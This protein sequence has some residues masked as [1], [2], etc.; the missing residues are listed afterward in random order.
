MGVDAG[1]STSTCDASCSRSLV[2]F[3]AQRERRRKRRRTHPLLAR[4]LAADILDVLRLEQLD[5]VGRQRLVAA[6]L[7]VDAALRKVSFLASVI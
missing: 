2:T 7:D 4:A 3:C 6:R 1:S 5:N